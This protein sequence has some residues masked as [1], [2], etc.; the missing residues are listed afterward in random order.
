MFDQTTNIP[1]KCGACLY[2]GDDFGD[3]TATLRCTEPIEHHPPH[4]KLYVRRDGSQRIEVTWTEDEREQCA[5]CKMKVDSTAYCD[6]CK[7]DLCIP[8]L[9]KRQPS[10]CT[11]C[12]GTFCEKCRPLHECDFSTRVP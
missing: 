4:R 1:T 2:L 10:N 12:Y 5:E 3:N 8:C 6:G 7:N 11:T 9:D